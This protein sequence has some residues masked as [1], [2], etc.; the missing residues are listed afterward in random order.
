MAHLL[1]K[2]YGNLQVAEVLVKIDDFGHASS[3]H[4]GYYACFQLIIHIFKNVINPP[5]EIPIDKSMHSFALKHMFVELG[6]I[7]RN[8]A[9]IFNDDFGA[10]KDLRIDSDYKDMPIDKPKAEKAYTIAKK[11]YSGMETAFSIR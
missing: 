3:I 11:L 7:D 5:K 6:K 9:G 10:L 2:S 4:C 1:T 8:F